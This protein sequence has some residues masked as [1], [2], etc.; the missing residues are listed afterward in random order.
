M[1]RLLL[2]LLLAS[3]CFGQLHE[4]LRPTM[5]ANNTGNDH[6]GDCIGTSQAS[7]AMPYSYDSAGLSTSSKL[8][9]YGVLNGQTFIRGR[10]FSGWAAAGETYTALTLNVNTSAVTAPFGAVGLTYSL[11][12]GSTWFYVYNGFFWS[13]QTFTITLTPGQS[14]PNIRIAN[15]VQGD[16]ITPGGSTITIWDTW[17]DGVYAGGGGGGTGTGVG[18]SARQPVIISIAMPFFLVRRLW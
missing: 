10:T 11:D 7:T 17:T 3:P 9:A 16:P 12:G 1:R 15:C 8:S 14:L 13:Q 18:N 4:I 5:D 2:F 6:L